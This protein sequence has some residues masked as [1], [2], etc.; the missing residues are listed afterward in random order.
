[1]RWRDEQMVHG[2]IAQ[3]WA[4]YDFWIDGEFSHCGID[5]FALAKGDTGWRIVGV[6]HTVERDGCEPSPLGLPR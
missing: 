6:S 5:S 1:M 3:L 2:R 4:P